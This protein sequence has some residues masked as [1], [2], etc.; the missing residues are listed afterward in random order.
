MLSEDKRI[1]IISGAYGS[2]KTEFAVNY[3]MR[4]KEEIKSDVVLAD[5]DIVNVYF[6]SRERREM[7]EKAGINLIYTSREGTALDLPAVSGRVLTPVRT[8]GYQAVLDMGGDEIGTKV[9]GR[10]KPY[11]KDEDTDLFM[12]IN[13]FRPGCDTPEGIL[14]EMAALENGTGRPFTGLINNSNLIRETTPETLIEG[15]KILKEVSRIAN[16]PIRYH[17][18]IEG[19][20]DISGLSLAGEPMP[21]KL[22]MREDWM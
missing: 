14:K 12:V 2:G 21:M 18:Y 15:D 22:Y 11:L 13:P 10:I 8:K 17:A 9:L 1:R 4:L 5:L 6:R 20:V 16:I 19:L 7:L 3:V